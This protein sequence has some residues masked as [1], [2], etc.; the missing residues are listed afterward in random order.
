MHWN[1]SPVG[2]QT[3]FVVYVCQC[4]REWMSEEALKRKKEIFDTY[5]VTTHWPVSRPP[6]RTC[7]C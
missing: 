5:K 3:R 6:P 1:Q 7:R 4:P 2:D